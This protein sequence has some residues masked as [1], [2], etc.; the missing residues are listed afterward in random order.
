MRVHFL[1]QHDGTHFKVVV[2]GRVPGANAFPGL[3][4]LIVQLSSNKHLSNDDESG[5]KRWQYLSPGATK[6][7]DYHVWHDYLRHD[8]SRE[9]LILVKREAEDLG[10]LVPVLVSTREGGE[11]L[12]LYPEK[13]LEEKMVMVPEF[14]TNHGMEL[15][16]LN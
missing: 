9:A 7:E 2:R 13:L 6:P 8:K 12:K 1:S 4:R 11:K 15:V 16:G 5:K 3:F 14:L 10:L